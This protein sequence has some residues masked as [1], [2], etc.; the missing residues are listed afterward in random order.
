[1]HE[2]PT[3]IGVIAVGEKAVTH[4]VLLSE[5]LRKIARKW[6][7]VC[8][9]TGGFKS[10]FKKADKSGARLAL[11][12][13]EDEVQQQT[14]GVKDLRTTGEQVTIPEQELHQYLEAYLG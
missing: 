5:S 2:E 1:M 4:A 11:I 7:I 10:Q 9:G 6:R 3:T 14:V 13:G 8:Y 12:L